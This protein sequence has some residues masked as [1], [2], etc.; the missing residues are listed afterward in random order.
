L[1]L[2]NIL[3]TNVDDVI[4]TSHYYWQSR[5]R[6]DMR[7]YNAR[8]QTS[9]YGLLNLRLDINNIARSNVSIGAFV[10]NLTNA[11][12]CNPEYSG[13]LNSAPNA[14]FGIAGTSGVLQCVPQAPR[15]YGVKLGYRF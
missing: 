3:G 14:T 5:Y 2:T 9:A 7:P 13:V 8:Q 10:Q 11:E 12:V 1:P 6:A 15:M 4:F